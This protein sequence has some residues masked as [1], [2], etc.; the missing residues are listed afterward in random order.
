MQS[1][2]AEFPILMISHFWL[3]VGL[4]E[5]RGNFMIENQFRTGR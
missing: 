4:N 5:W 1:K 3:V 2:S